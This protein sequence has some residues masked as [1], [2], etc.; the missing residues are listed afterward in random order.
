MNNNNE[1]F[2][3]FLVGILIG[4]A[5]IF[6]AVSIDRYRHQPVITESPF[7]FADTSEGH[8]HCQTDMR[9]SDQWSPRLMYLNGIWTAACVAQSEIEGDSHE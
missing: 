5:L 3:W 7:G 1:V 8:P 2:V 4:V 9:Y 6:T